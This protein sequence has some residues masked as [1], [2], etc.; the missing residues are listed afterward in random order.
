VPQRTINSYSQQAAGQA[1][2][3]G[4]FVVR[5]PGCEKT[6]AKSCQQEADRYAQRWREAFASA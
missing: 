3:D 5:F 4:D 1:Y 2:V 6:G